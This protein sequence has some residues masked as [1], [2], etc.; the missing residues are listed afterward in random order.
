ME[1]LINCFLIIIV[2]STVLSGLVFNHIS[3][4]QPY[5]KHLVGFSNLDQFQ[6]GNSE[7]LDNTVFAEES[8]A[9]NLL[10]DT[11]ISE[12]KR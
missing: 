11:C 5:L 9:F 1:I 7:K 2:L 6:S 8:A 3:Y 10:T 4:F 12:Q